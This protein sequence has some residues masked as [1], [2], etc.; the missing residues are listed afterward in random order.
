MSYNI[1]THNSIFKKAKKNHNKQTNNN[2]QQNK[3][4]ECNTVR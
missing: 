1:D 2:T 4:T 3:K